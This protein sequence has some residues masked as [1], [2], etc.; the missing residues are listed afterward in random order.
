MLMSS[1]YTVHSS[2]LKYGAVSEIVS[3][4]VA[5]ICDLVLVG[6]LF[7]AD[8]SL[9][10]DGLLLADGS[11]LIGDLVFWTGGLAFFV[12]HVVVVGVAGLMV[13]GRSQ[14]LVDCQVKYLYAA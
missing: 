2:I 10:A 3:G 6:G 7:L 13:I 11:S 4:S 1:V 8:G 14:Q 5:L 9:L 12:D